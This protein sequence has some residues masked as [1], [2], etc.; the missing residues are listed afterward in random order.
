MISAN[1]S[2]VTQGRTNSARCPRNRQALGIA[3]V[4]NQHLHIAGA[5]ECPWRGRDCGKRHEDKDRE[6][7]EFHR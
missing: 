1:S 7:F 4:T 6:K 5:D 2:F 3:T